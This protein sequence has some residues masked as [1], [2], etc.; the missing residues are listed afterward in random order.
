METGGRSGCPR[1]HHSLSPPPSPPPAAHPRRSQAGFLGPRS[2]GGRTQGRQPPL[3]VPGSSFKNNIF[4]RKWNREEAEGTQS[5]VRKIGKCALLVGPLFFSEIMVQPGYRQRGPKTEGTP[6]A[7][8]EAR[9]GMSQA[10]PHGRKLETHL[11]CQWWFFLTSL[12]PFS[13]PLCP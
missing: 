11:F 10:S 13:R 4:A 5:R 9:E 1:L 7:E 2:R 3:L 8:L 12:R 6:R